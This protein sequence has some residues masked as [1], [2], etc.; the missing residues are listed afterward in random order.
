[1]AYTINKTDGTVLT[2]IVDNTLDETSNLQLPGRGYVGYGESHN[3]NFV[4]LLENFANTTANAPSKPIVGQLFYD[5]TLDQMQVYDGSSF[6][7]VSGAIISASTPSFG[8]QGDLWYNSTSS[9]LYVYTGTAYVLV[10]PPSSSTTGAITDTITDNTGTV[11]NVVKLTVDNNIV[12]IISDNEFTPQVSLTGYETVKKGITLGTNITT[13]RFQGTA[14]DSDKLGGVLAANYLRSDT[15]DTL[16][17]TLTIKSDES[18]VLG[19]DSDIVMSQDAANFTIR[20]TS[21]N[22]DIIFRVNDGG[23]TTTALTIDGDTSSLDV[24]NNLTVSGTTTLSALTMTSGTANLNNLTVQGDLNVEGTQTILNTS[25]VEIE[26]PILLLSNNTSGAPSSNAGIQIKRGSSDDVTFI[27]NES[28]DK[29]TLGTETL[30]A[31]TFEGNLTGNVTG[32]VVGNTTGTHTGDVSGDV[33]GDVVGNLTGD[34]VASTVITNVVRSTDSALIELQ[35]SLRVT[36]TLQTNVIESNDST[37]VTINDGL[38]VEGNVQAATSVSSNKVF[39][40][41]IES[42]DSSQVEVQDTLVVTGSIIFNEAS[43]ADSSAITIRDGVRIT[44]T[45]QIDIGSLP[46]SDP[47]NAGQLFRDGTD[48]KV[49]IG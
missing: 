15:A 4:K 48:L 46:T 10:G 27:W 6:R 16:S 2:T 40:N 47:N 33:T 42:M 44:G 29:W 3:E 49:S 45:V 34:V 9:Q 20:N 43:S 35:D 8:A 21:S 11:N 17:G 22:G 24:P 5:T 26:D 12:A 41:Q 18:L 30:I 37:T 7:A 39:A 19:V 23:V 28:T 14:T 32:N 36:G 25:T 31:G 1:M 13:N 38:N